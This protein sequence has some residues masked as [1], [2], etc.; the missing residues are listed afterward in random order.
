MLE[1]AQ[2]ALAKS[3]PNTS[4]PNFSQALM[5]VYIMYYDVSATHT[6]VT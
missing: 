1:T 2:K 6:V 3:F 4:F 5:I